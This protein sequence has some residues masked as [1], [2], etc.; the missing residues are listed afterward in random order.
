MNVL[1]RKKKYKCFVL[2]KEEKHG[3]FKC[4]H[5]WLIWIPSLGHIQ[6]KFEYNTE[7]HRKFE[8]RSFNVAYV[9]DGVLKIIFK[10]MKRLGLSASC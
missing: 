10:S 3:S 7:F 8:K 5:F 9:N 4:D 6:S 2:L 1:R